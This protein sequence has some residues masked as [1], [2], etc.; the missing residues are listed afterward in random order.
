MATEKPAFTP[1]EQRKQDHIRLAL[2]DQNQAEGLAAITLP[3]EA[4]PDLNFD[5]ISLISQRLSVD[6]PT[7]FFVSSMTAG[8]EQALT[9]N[10]HLW[11]A[12]AE[13][14]WAL[15]VGSQRRELTDVNAASEWNQLR[16]NS[17]GVCLYGNLGLSQL[18]QTSIDDIEQLCQNL[19][20]RAMIIH[21][22]PL[23]ECLQPEGT[24]QFAGGFQALEALCQR[25]SRPVILK[26]TGCGFSRD[27]LSRLRE[28]GLSAIDISGYGGTHWGRIEGE[29][30]PDASP[31]A[32]A[33]Q[34]FR[35]WGINTV[36]SCKNAVELATDYEVWASGG[37]RS[38]LDAAKCLA[39]GATQIG[40]AQPLLSAAMESTESV[41]KTM[42]QFEYELKIALF[43]TGS[44]TIS[45]LK[46]RYHA[47]QP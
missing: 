24:P 18:I 5:D 37:I 26:E 40:I 46:E 1:F 21:T 4:M 17:A 6:S 45:D 22:N 43:C 15:G 13:T 14:G 8:H 39:L 29:R 30:A 41:I 16:G 28:I 23:Q 47:T 34:T 42:Q 19:Q 33:A 10:R 3:H 7:P 38:G 20:A 2:S 27:T 12:C 36:T 31:Q 44:R 9:I 32:L 25:L 11:E 35:Q